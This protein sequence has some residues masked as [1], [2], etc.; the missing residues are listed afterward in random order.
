MKRLFVTCLLLCFLCSACHSSGA[1]LEPPKESQSV[2][3]TEN[4]DMELLNPNEILDMN[5]AALRQKRDEIYAGR[6]MS[7]LLPNERYNIALLDYAVSF[8]YEREYNE[9]PVL[10]NYKTYP[11][12]QAVYEDLNG[13]G[14]EDEIIVSCTIDRD[15]S[16]MVNGTKIVY[17]NFYNLRENFAIVDI[18][19]SDNYKEIAISFMGPSGMGSSVFF[20]YDGESV[21]CMNEGCN[22]ERPVTGGRGNDDFIGE[23]FTRIGCAGDG[24]IIGSQRA[25]LLHTWFYPIR[26]KLSQDHRLEFI[27]DDVFKVDWPVFT[28]RPLTLYTE[29]TEDS[30]TIEMDMGIIARLTALDDIEWVQVTLPGGEEGWFKLENFNNIIDKSGSFWGHEVFFHLRYAA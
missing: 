8:F 2:T 13:D 15:V 28:L 10:S 30:P 3:Q 11:I 20:Y 25:A 21:V 5:E 26:Y 1:P 29:R 9:S 16:V 6:L 4:Q 19:T 17:E 22:D 18:D 27:P 14:T 24:I 23:N 7:E 12:N